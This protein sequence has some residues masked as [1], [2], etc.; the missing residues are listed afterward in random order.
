MFESQSTS[1][2]MQRITVI[3][4]ED[5]RMTHLQRCYVT[6]D[7]CVGYYDVVFG[8]RQV[9][10]PAV[11]QGVVHGHLSYKSPLLRRR[12]DLDNASPSP[13]LHIAKFSACAEICHIFCIH[14]Q[15]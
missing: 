9:V 1:C 8:G 12:I 2:I 6:D 4:S 5:L 11:G 3:Q 7:R 13:N 15:F 14:V 10:H